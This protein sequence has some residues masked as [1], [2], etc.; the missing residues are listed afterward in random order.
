MY[1]QFERK[2]L[3]VKR[4]SLGIYTDFLLKF[5]GGIS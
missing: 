4:E 3:R 2:K 1:L 5:G